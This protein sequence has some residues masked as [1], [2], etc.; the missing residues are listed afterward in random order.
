[1]F[2]ERECPA[3][4]QPTN[5]ATCLVCG[6]ET[7]ERPVAT[8]STGLM[9]SSIYSPADQESI[10]IEGGPYQPPTEVTFLSKNE[11]K[12][13]L[14]KRI[15]GWLLGGLYLYGIPIMCVWLAITGHLTIL[16]TIGACF[17]L[18]LVY[19]RFRLKSL[20]G[21]IIDDDDVKSRVTAPVLELCT[22]MG[23]P[24]PRVRI[25]QTLNPI[26][27]STYH[28][29]PLL[30][31][32]PDFL[33]NVDDRA[34][35]AIIAHE[36]IHQRAGDVAAARARG[37]AINFALYLSFVVINFSASGGFWGFAV[38]IAFLFP[39][40]AI[41]A[42]VAGFWWR[43]RESRADIEGLLA[44]KDREASIRGLRA[45]HAMVPPRRRMVYGPTAVR[46]LLL[47]Y[48]LRARSHPSL[49]VRVAAL[50]AIDLDDELSTMDTPVRGGHVRQRARIL[51]GLVVLAS[52]IGVGVVIRHVTSNAPF[53]SKNVESP[54]GAHFI[55]TSDLGIPSQDGAFP[56][57]WNF[58]P[59]QSDQVLEVSTTAKQAVAKADESSGANSSSGVTTTVAEGSFA[60]VTIADFGTDP[61]GGPGDGTPA[62]LVVYKGPYIVDAENGSVNDLCIVVVDA[63][64]D[65]VEQKYYY[66]V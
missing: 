60:G 6:H 8:A 62:Y 61:N 19:L 44:S 3:C 38:Y 33:E 58:Y 41:V 10:Q 46:W 1:M 29:D 39:S 24:A 51:I 28:K 14:R 12:P 34:L 42:W 54:G 30:C 7:A 64:D 15:V 50:E 63:T 31:I 48:S 16:F 4:G 49:S 9:G 20:T 13:A 25:Q 36:L 45:V 23:I 37:V 2:F 32:S 40:L 53:I 27:M 57:H 56:E 47:P 18:Q 21:P 65:V 17:G 5:A 55:P 11:T 66:D 35:R 22:I 43:P 59:L 52:A 26:A